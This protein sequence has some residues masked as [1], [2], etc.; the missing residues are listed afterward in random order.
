MTSPV[1][2]QLRAEATRHGET[3]AQAVRHHLMNGVVE[4]IA[5]TPDA[6]SFVLR[7]GLLTRAWVAP[8]PRP[9]RDLDY[10]G[11][12]PFDV[13]DTRRRLAPAL[14]IELPDEV[15]FDLAHFHTEGIWLD[16]EFP[17]VR[18]TLSLG[19]GVVD[20]RLTMDIGFRDPLVPEA[21]WIE[22]PWSVRV[23][24]VRPETQIAWKLH[25]LAEMGPSFRPKD[26]ADL[27]LITRHVA[28]DP[29]ALPPAIVAAFE[30][31][32]F[33]LD[34]ART[35]LT[36]PH[37]STKTARV[38]WRTQRPRGPDLPELLDDVRARLAPALKELPCPP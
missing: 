11:D 20:D 38:R 16:T 13:E 21:V 5:R 8:A 3:M 18:V 34:Q 15:V 33:T 9:T 28:L 10:V 25:A 14:S 12:F 31:R 17:G 6:G 22:A 7:G 1:L 36:A 27:W 29:A 4:R 37:W 19:L 2:E 26:V 23:R 35:T 24:A 32:G 30:S